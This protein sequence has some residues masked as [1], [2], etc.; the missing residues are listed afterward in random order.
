MVCVACTVLGCEE[1]LSEPRNLGW[2]PT[3][4]TL[5]VAPRVLV[6]P[7]GDTVSAE[8]QTDAPPSA[9]YIDEPPPG[10]TVL[11]LEDCCVAGEGTVRFAVDPDATLGNYEIDFRL[12][13]SENY[14]ADPGELQLSVVGDQT[15]NPL[16]L[17]TVV[18]TG[19]RPSAFSIHPDG[20]RAFVPDKNS[21]TITSIDLEDNRASWTAR[22]HPDD[23]PQIPR[24]GDGPVAIAFTAGDTAYIANRYSDLLTRRVVSTWR[25]EPL[26]VPVAAGPSAVALDT[27][28][29]L[30]YV[31]AWDGHEVSV[32][33]LTTHEVTDSIAVGVGPYDIAIVSGG[34]AYVTNW[35]SD[36]VS[37]IDLDARSVV[38]TIP[39]GDRP[40]GLT[41]SADH[42]VAYVANS[43]SDDMSI[44][45]L[46]TLTVT[47]TVEVG[48]APHEVAV[49]S[50]GTTAYVANAESDDVSIVDL[51][52]MQVVGSVAVG[53]SPVAVALRPDDTFL[54]VVNEW[55]D[56]VYVFDLRDPGVLDPSP[57]PR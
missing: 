40:I 1:N 36:Y 28:A 14:L 41:L 48:S 23:E 22:V 53:D 7:M 33:D 19:S 27:D 13:G 21:H 16:R 47:G 17:S 10:V 5:A 2:G 38:A 30:A 34:T 44:I 32:V 29:R 55:G 15:D 24:M 42:T 4:Y 50:D 49:T 25:E 3:E 35:G 26:D 45:D 6:A 8:L 43:G 18:V 54:Y 57:A 20:R 51:A 39:V 37:V 9:L 12:E 56:D 52:A 31:T 46:A 11:G